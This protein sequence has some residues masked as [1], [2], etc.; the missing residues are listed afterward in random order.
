MPISNEKARAR[1]EKYIGKTFGEWEVIGVTDEFYVIGQMRRRKLLCRCSCKAHTVRAVRADH[2]IHGISTSCG[3][4]KSKVRSENM[5]AVKPHM[6]RRNIITP[7]LWYEDKG[8]YVIGHTPCG[9]IFYIDKCDYPI[10]SQYVW[11]IHSTH[12]LGLISRK[13]GTSLTM[14]Q[15]LMRIHKFYKVKYKNG[16]KLDY[17]MEN[18]DI[19]PMPEGVYFN[20]NHNKWHVRL[21]VDGKRETIGYYSVARDAVRALGQAKQS[22]VEAKL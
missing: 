10:I 22:I 21:T 11:G 12:G 19:T 7:T 17:R 9:Y 18:L 13:G 3:C 20:K 15:L 1:Y 5:K 16:N 8:E 4:V 6:Y 14:I 2:V